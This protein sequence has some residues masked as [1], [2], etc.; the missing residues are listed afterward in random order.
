MSSILSHLKPAAGS[1][2]RSKRIARGQGSGHGGTATH[3]HK[4]DQSR[5]GYKKKRNFEG[6]QTPIQMRLPK[7]GFKN[8]NRVEYSP[9][10]LSELQRLVDKHNLSSVDAEVLRKLR[11]IRRSDK[12]KVLGN[13]TLRSAVSVSLHAF[14]EKAKQAIESAGGTA[15]VI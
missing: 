1:M 9:L 8:I 15:T 10:N 5:S 11:V 13:G 6:G 2:K 7:R 3:G 4:G 14:S 12:V